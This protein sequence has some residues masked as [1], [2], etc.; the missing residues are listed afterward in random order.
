MMNSHTIDGRFIYAV[1]IACIFVNLAGCA[2]SGGSAGNFRFQSNPGSSWGSGTRSFDT[3]SFEQGT[4][5][6]S[7]ST[8]ENQRGNT[9]PGMDRAGSPPGS[10][11]IVDQAGMLTR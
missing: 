10:G 5:P 6:A 1:A 9:P 11:A 4:T 8:P 7:S 3:R 2:G